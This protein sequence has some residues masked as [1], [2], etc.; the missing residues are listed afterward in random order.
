MLSF[1]SFNQFPFFLAS[2][3]K[4]FPLTDPSQMNKPHNS[5]SKIKYPTKRP[6][7]NSSKVHHILKTKSPIKEESEATKKN[8]FIG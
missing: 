5:R 1:Y 3:A 4:L 8:E 2:L 7:S 6:S